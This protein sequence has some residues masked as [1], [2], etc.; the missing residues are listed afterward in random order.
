[1]S[2]VSSYGNG[3]RLVTIHSCIQLVNESDLELV[4]GLAPAAAQGAGQGAAAA[5]ELLERLPP[6]QAVWLPVQVSVGS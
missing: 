6:G 1:M 4:M 5:A 3:S 2:E